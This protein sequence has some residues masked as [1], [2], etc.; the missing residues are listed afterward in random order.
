MTAREEPLLESWKEISAYLKRSVRTCRRWESKLGLPIHR[1]DGTPSAR[2]FAYPAELD[3]WLGEKLRHIE[4]DERAAALQPVLKKKKLLMI[5]GAVATAVIVLGG[6][7]A[8]LTPLLLT[9]LAPPPGVNPVLA[10]LPFENPSGDQALEDWRIALPDLLITDLRQ[11]RYLEVVPV[12]S[13]YAQLRDMK[14]MDVPKLSDD[15]LTGIAKRFRQDFTVTGKL[16]RKGNDIAVEIAIRSAKPAEGFPLTLRSAAQDEKALIDEADDLS[17]EIKKATGLTRREIASDV[18]APL[19]RIATPI[20][21]AWKLYARADWPREWGPYPDMVPA[22]EKALAIDPEFGLAC[23]LMYTGYGISHVE[24]LVRWYEKALSLPGRLSER[25]SLLLRA[26]FY[27]FCRFQRGL[28]KLAAAGV[29]EA[30]IDRLGP[31]TR[32]EVLPVLERLSAL[33]PVFYGSPIHLSNLVRIYM[34]A[35]DWDRAIAI[36][37]RVAPLT[38]TWRPADTTTLFNCYLNRGWIDKAEATIAG[39]EKAAPP[40]VIA[41]MRNSVA[42]KRGQFNEVLGYLDKEYDAPGKR[43][44]P[45]AYYA[46]RGYVLWLADDLLGAER[47]HR[48]AIPGA[49]PDIEIQRAKDLAAVSLSQGKIE[50]ALAEVSKGFGIA[51]NAKDPNVRGSVRSLRHFRAYLYRLAGRL[52]EA[53]KDADESCFDY[54]GSD[55]EPGLAVSLLHLRALI[56]LDLGLSPDFERRLEEIRAFC[57][58]EGTP[59]FM[60]AWHHLRG[61]QELGRGRGQRAISEFERALDLS[62][63]ETRRCDQAPVLFSLA[64]AHESLG[65]A[66][67]AGI[68]FDGIS[69]PGERGSL[70]GDVYALSFYRKAKIYES[71]WRGAMFQPNV[72]SRK[73][74]IE[75]Y[76]KFLSLWRDADPLFA[77]QVED[78]R[79]RLAALESE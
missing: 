7:A 35:E 16:E 45:Y 13:L 55:I 4:A 34:G 36:L 51:E 40:P 42:M 64:E 44:Y 47:A 6:G 31:K 68:S 17:R 11:S 74:A 75:G 65:N 41:D 37:E 12:R 32:R 1:L 48:T 14:R 15:D 58:K 26:D 52:P 5:A 25:E 73:K 28:T 57:N 79:R 3:Q 20:P 23:R 78:A 10:I 59:K 69:K 27:H 60:R 62:T 50:Q 66:N 43:P 53:L 2:V 72:E 30:T 56:T 70:T 9:K 67:A 77:A 54:Q 46:E 18:D 63:P 49:G 61:L 39:F 24:E 71:N 21:E 33:Y 19:R 76:R 22:L 8:L 29:P 38:M